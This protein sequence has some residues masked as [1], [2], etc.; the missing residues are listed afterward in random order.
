MPKEGLGA[1]PWA[2]A[3]V[4]L[5]RLP[6]RLSI[7]MSLIILQMSRISSIT[8]G[9]CSGMMYA[10]LL[11]IHANS[12]GRLTFR[13]PCHADKDNKMPYGITLQ[14]QTDSDLHV[15][16]QVSRSR[17]VP[18]TP[19]GQQREMFIDNFNTGNQK[20]RSFVLAYACREDSL[21]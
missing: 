4:R 9:D 21:H 6:P 12:L 16:F 11:V 19:M 13:I 5:G 14:R 8:A 17:T 2:S 20:M 18:T 15:P 7:W 1:M 3:I 10:A